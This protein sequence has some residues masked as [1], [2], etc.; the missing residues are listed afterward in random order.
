M[1][2]KLGE[3]PKRQKN[4]REKKSEKRGH[5]NKRSYKK[6]RQNKRGKNINETL[7]IFW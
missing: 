6:I 4:R 3:I 5:L 2:D 1:E 7:N